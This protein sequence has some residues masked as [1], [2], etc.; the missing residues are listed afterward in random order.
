MRQIGQDVLLTLQCAK[1][2]GNIQD[3]TST[4]SDNYN[5]VSTQL[6]PSCIANALLY[7]L[8]KFGIRNTVFFALNHSIGALTLVITENNN[9][10]T[11][12][13]QT[14]RHSHFDFNSI[15]WIFVFINQ[16]SPEFSTDLFF[17]IAII[18]YMVIRRNICDF[19]LAFFSNNMC[20]TIFYCSFEI[21]HL[22][23]S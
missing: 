21:C 17:W 19:L 7:C 13:R 8:V 2:I 5:I 23:S 11:I 14:I 1:F 22:R 15:D 6:H 9:I 4:T 18:F 20:I 12:C 10:S 3:T 16:F